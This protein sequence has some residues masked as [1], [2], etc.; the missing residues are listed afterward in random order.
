MILIRFYILDFDDS[1]YKLI[2]EMRKD[3]FIITEHIFE[4]RH[5]PS[6]RFLDVRGYVSDHIKSSGLFQHWE[7]NPT[8]IHFRDGESKI[9]KTG[10]FAG[11]KSAGYFAFD[12]ETRNY[13]ED[14]SIQFWKKLK[15]NQFYTIPELIRLGCRTK[16]FITCDK[17]FDDIHSM[18]YSNLFTGKVSDMI[19]KEEKDFQVIMDLKLSEYDIHM[20]IGPIHKNEAGNFFSFES[21]HFENAG[22]FL[23]LDVSKQS[24]LSQNNIPSYVKDAMKISWE[25][26]DGITSILG[27]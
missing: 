20:S 5:A 19:G 12:P 16:A 22:I 8:V 25:R 15:E 9:E 21:K 6:G 4:V 26:I 11:Y 18:L 1:R 3:S 14:K 10:A 27:I 23:D 24:G 17:S 2:L 7:I 13:F